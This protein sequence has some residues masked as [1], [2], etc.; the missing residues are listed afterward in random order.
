MEDSL[1]PV[2]FRLW[3]L[4]PCLTCDGWVN[5][6]RS[7]DKFNTLVSAFILTLFW[8][9]CLLSQAAFAEDEW[10]IIG[11]SSKGTLFYNSEPVAE[12]SAGKRGVWIK[13]VCNAEG[14]KWLQSQGG[15]FAGAAYVTYYYEINCLERITSCRWGYVYSPKG[16]SFGPL[17]CSGE[18]VEGTMIFPK[19]F[20]GEFLLEKFCP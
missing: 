4:L 3:T 15:K 8:E 6:G 16:E 11:L 2:C 14:M 9:A 13:F 19:T 20:P 1:K 17:D 10:K 12:L 5:K 18:G 7:L